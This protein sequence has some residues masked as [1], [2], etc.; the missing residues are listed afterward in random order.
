MRSVV[1]QL[2]PTGLDNLGFLS[3]VEWLVQTYKKHTGI[4]VEMLLPKENILME[5]TF[6]LAAYRITQEC[7]T[8]IAK[9][10]NASKVHIE[11]NKTEGFL[12][13][14]VHDNGIGLPDDVKTSGHGIFG[15]IERTRYLG[16]SIDLFSDVT[17]TTVHLRLP[18]AAI[19]PKNVKRVLIVDDHAIVRNALRQLLSKEANDF[20]VE[21]EAADGKIALQMAIDEEWDI[22][23]LDITLP[24]MSGLQVLEAVMKVKPKQA[25]IMLSSHPEEEYG[26]TARSKGAACYIEKGKTDK[27]VE[28]MLR[29]TLPK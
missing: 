2:Y 28:A 29:A 10:A 8:N 14:L 16:G 6:E 1:S 18:L 22:I 17:G 4:E 9:H 25:I 20:S 19:K 7:L 23:L 21:G 12:D 27:L 11:I 5:Q 26:E 13:L 24:K 3:A 15:M